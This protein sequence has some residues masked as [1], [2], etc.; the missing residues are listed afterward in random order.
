MVL[1]N[2][3]ASPVALLPLPVVLLS[4]ASAFVAVLLPPVVFL[5]RALN[6]LA[7][8][9][10]PVVLA[11]MAP[12][13]IPCGAQFAHPC[14]SSGPRLISPDFPYSSRGVTS[15]SSKR[16]SICARIARP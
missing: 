13:S 12:R 16:A 2:S 5:E 10:L 14:G 4:S 7:V 11:A 9:L 1:L 6:P 15:Q 3:A 8:L